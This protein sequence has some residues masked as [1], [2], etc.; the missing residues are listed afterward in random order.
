MNSKVKKEFETKEKT[1]ISNRNLNKLIN[2][3]MSN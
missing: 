3:I 1:T 2:H